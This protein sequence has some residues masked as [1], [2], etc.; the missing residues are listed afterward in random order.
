MAQQ[1]L[2][3]GGN[4]MG[5]IRYYTKTWTI[6]EKW[7]AVALHVLKRLRQDCLNQSKISVNDSTDICLDQGLTYIKNS[8]SGKH[9]Q[10][11]CDTAG[12][13]KEKF[14]RTLNRDIK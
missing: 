14:L 6:E 2:L 4:N 12:V 7:R 8:S 3:F 10:Y 13:S 11:W 9:L 5:G 1:L